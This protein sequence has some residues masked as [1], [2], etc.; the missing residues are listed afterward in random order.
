MHA[1]SL[2][3]CLI[4]ARSGI[5]THQQRMAVISHNIA[6]INTPGYHRQRAV[7]GTTP[8]NQSNIFSVRRYD[9]GTGVQILTVTRAYDETRERQYL[10]LNSSMSAN[11]LLANNLS[12]VESLLNSTVDGVSLTDHLNNFWAAWQDVATNPTDL[13]M[14]SV[15]LERSATLT[16][17][18]NSLATN[19]DGYATDL[20]SAAEP[21][22]GAIPTTIEQINSLAT[23]IQKLNQQITVAKAQ[24]TNANDLL[25]QRNILIRDL[26]AL[27]NIT[28]DVDQTIRIDGEVLVSGNG[29]TCNELT[30]N[31]TSPSLQ[32]ALDGSEVTVAGGALGGYT[33]TL[34]MV[35]TLRSNLDT[36]ASGLIG[37]LNEWHT[38]GYD[39]N[40]DSGLEFFTGSSASDIRVNGLL[41]DYTNPLLSNPEL[42]AAAT[43]LHTDPPG[44]PNVGDG[45]NALRIAELS[46][47][48]LDALNGRTCTQYF[49]DMTAVVGA[50]QA[51][52]EALAD[53]SQIALE[54]LESAM[55]ATD[56]VSLDEELLD[57]MSAQ[58]AF[59][60]ASQLA[61]TINEMM[62][63]VI[64]TV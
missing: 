29:L 62:Q 16:S 37:R 18:F 55:L 21:P 63:M 53:E 6:N 26:S 34:N 14:R 25:D 57:M 4:I 61:T 13:A 17:A 19:L 52:A 48:G 11:S 64:N 22:T 42:V 59:A 27:A 12:G 50:R 15:L 8:P 23:R 45:S 54:A 43:T 20:L 39:L 30:I 41:Y 5:L 10:N 40:G 58:R 46:Q 56:G 24:Q 47:V 7:L 35:G 33:Q 36:L 38:G 3:D 2:N 1:G 9:L 60:A 31:A 44:G 28:M 51:G 32:F 49:T